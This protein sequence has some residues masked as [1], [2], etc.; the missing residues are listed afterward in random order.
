MP[1]GGAEFD[2]F[3]PAAEQFDAVGGLRALVAAVEHAGGKSI[4][5]VVLADGDVLRPQRDPHLL[6]RAERMQQRHLAAASVAEIDR[7]KFAVAR[8]QRARKF[9]GGAGEIGDEQ[10]RRPVIDRVRRIHLQQFAVAHHADAVAEHHGF[11][12]VMGD[13]ERGHAG[14]L[15]DHAQIVAQT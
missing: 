4:G 7:A 13:I 8:H 12:L 3:Q 9:V 15:E 2:H 6:V 10:I 5:A 11:G 14:L 1:R